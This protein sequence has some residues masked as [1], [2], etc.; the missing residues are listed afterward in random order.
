MCDLLI[1]VKKS[2]LKNLM[3]EKNGL[4]MLHKL[5]PNFLTFFIGIN[6]SFKNLWIFFFKFVNTNYHCR[7]F[8]TVRSYDLNTLT[9][10]LKDDSSPIFIFR[11]IL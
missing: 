10:S 4:F 1:S 9:I 3:V 7:T 5:S 2:F 6:V 11:L 8:S